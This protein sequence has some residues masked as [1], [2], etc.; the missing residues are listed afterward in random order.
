MDCRRALVG[1]PSEREIEEL[2]P[3]DLG[4]VGTRVRFVIGVELLPHNDPVSQS[5]LDEILQRLAL[6]TP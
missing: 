4:H 1:F 5:L 2:I 3:N 6:K